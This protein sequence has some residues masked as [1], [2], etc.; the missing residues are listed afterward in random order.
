MDYGGIFEMFCKIK[1]LHEKAV[2]IHLHCF[3]NGRPPQQELEKYCAE[4]HYYPRKTGH[5][6]I[7]LKMPYI[8][9]SRSDHSLLDNLLKDDFPILLEGIHCSFLLNDN[10]FAGR[11]V[12]LRLH[13]VEC[14]YYRQLFRSSVSLFK[15][16]Y[17]LH[18]SVVLHGYEK[19]LANKA[20]IL[21]MS[22]RDNEFYKSEFGAERVYTVPVFQPFRE[23]ESQ[24]GKGCF[25]LYHGNLSVAENE[26][27]AIWL[28]K[29]VFN[30]LSIPLVIAGK[31]PSQRLIR[32]ASA[33]PHACV[34]ANPSEEEIQDIIGKAQVHVL[35]S[36]NC[37]GIKLKLLNALFNG[38][39]CVANAPMLESTGLESLC[40]IAGDARSFKE[41]IVAAYEAP[42]SAEEILYRKEILKSRFCNEAAVSKLIQLIW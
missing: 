11:A 12:F 39:H 31:D 40:A 41:E 28:L 36:F 3:E 42:F 8:V 10:R 16:S 37:T 35:P 15:K 2:Q 34:V 38:R 9:C 22:D 18:E 19:K 27:A 30:D 24:T 23:V 4:I 7:S 1:S 13:N 29:K 20:V 32:L 26:K 25:C 33:N 17:Y 21:A 6:G 14:V 5:K